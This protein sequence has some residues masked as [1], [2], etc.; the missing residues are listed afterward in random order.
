MHIRNRLFN[1]TSRAIICL[2]NVGSG[3][4]HKMLLAATIVSVA[5]CAC[6][7]SEVSISTADRVKIVEEKQKIDPKFY[8]E[9]KTTEATSN[10]PPD[11]APVVPATAQA[12]QSKA[13]AK[14]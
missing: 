4:T 9:K 1:N 10:K 12:E 13:S 11:V 5:L 2:T 14:M 8:L 6:G 3:L 7:K